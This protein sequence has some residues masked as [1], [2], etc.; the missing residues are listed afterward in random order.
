MAHTVEQPSQAERLEAV[1]EAPIAG[2][3]ATD[4][5]LTGDPSPRSSDSAIEHNAS[6]KPAMAEPQAPQRSAGKIALI[7]GSLCVCM[8]STFPRA[9][10]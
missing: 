2:A 8:R 5:D 6:E 4:K 3:G 7:M 9:K 1:A 10:C